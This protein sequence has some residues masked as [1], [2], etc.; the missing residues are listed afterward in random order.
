MRIKFRFT[1]PIN[2]GKGI[3][4]TAK[5]LLRVVIVLLAV[6]S[7]IWLT[8]QNSRIQTYLVDQVTASLK[9][10]LGIEVSVGRV[11]FRPFASLLLRDV[12]I[13]DLKGDT[14]LHSGRIAVT[15]LGLKL[16]PSNIELGRANFDQTTFNF[17]TDS[18]GVMNLS[19]LIRKIKETFPSK[20]DSS[21]FRLSANSISISNSR[22][23]LK[24]TAPKARNSDFGMNFQDMNFSNFNLKVDNLY[25]H[26]DTV[27]L[28]I[29]SLNFSDHSGFKLDNLR[30]NFS[31]CRSNMKF[32]KLRLQAHDSNI[33]LNR[34][35]FAFSSWKDFGNFVHSVELDAQFAGTYLKT[36][37]LSYFAP[38]FR[39]VDLAVSV[40]GH[41][42]GTISD[43][44][45]KGLELRYGSQ[46]L[47]RTNFNITGLPDIKQTLMVIDLYELSTNR[48]DLAA[49][50]NPSSGKPLVNLPQN[51]DML[52]TLTYKGNFTGYLNN[53]V[54]YGNLTSAIGSIAVDLSF[55]PDKSNNIDING[56]LRTTQLDVGK[57]SNSPI[58]GK[59]TL[60]ASLN[61]TID[62]QRKINFFTNATINSLQANSYTYN[63][64]VISGNLTNK[65]YSGSVRLNDPNCKLNF[66]GIIDFSDTIPV[67]DFSAFV[68]KLDLVKLNL[69]KKDSVSQ[70]SFLLTTKFRGSNLDNSSGEIKVVNSMYRNQHGEFKL[71]DVTINADNKEDSKVITLQ[72]DFAEGE[73][74]SKYNYSKFFTYLNNLVLK[75]IPAMK[76]ESETESSTVAFTGV[77][78]PE[79]NDYLVKFRLKKTEKITSVLMPQLSIAEN[80]SIFGILNPDLQTFSFKVRVP[81]MRFGNTGIKDL[82]AEGQ[83]KDSLFTASINTPLITIGSSKIENFKISSYLSHNLLNLAIGWQNTQ[84]PASRGLIEATADFTSYN[85]NGQL[86]SIAFNPSTFVINDS[87][88]NLSPST[89][90]IDTASVKFNSFSIRSRNQ[91]FNIDGKLSASNMDTLKVNLLNMDISYLNLYLQ[92]RG[93]NVSGTINGFAEIN[94][95]YQNPTLFSKLS[96][97]KLILN[98]NPIGNVTFSSTWINSEKR[99]AV[100]LTNNHEDTLTLKATGNLYTDDGSM[101]FLVDVNRVKLVHL[102]PLLKGSVSDLSGNVNGKIR[103]NGKTSKPMLNGNLSFSNATLTVDFLKSTFTIND[104]ISVDNSNLYFR[105]FKIT[106]RFNRVATINGDIKTNSFKDINFNIGMAAENFLCMNTTEHDNSQFYGTVFGTGPIFITGKPDNLNFNINLKTEGK[107]AIYL[108]IS[109]EKTVKQN[110]FISF[111]SSNPDQI[112][113]DEPVA[114]KKSK[115]NLNLNLDLLVTPDAEVQIIIDKKLGD[116]IKANGSGNLKMEISPEK[117]VFRMF[118]NFDIEKG[119]YLF[120]LQGVINKK[121][122]IMPGSSITWNGGPLDATMNIEAAYRVKTSLKQLLMDERYTTRVPVD[123]K[124]FLT[125]KLTSPVIKFGIEVP[126]ADAETKALVDGALN[127]EEKVNTQFLGLLVINSFI[128][129]PNQAGM[130]TQSS[131]SMGTM[132][133]YNTASE[134][135]SNQF[136][137]WISQWSN[138]VDIGVNYRP[139]MESELSSNQMEV[140]LSTQLLNDRVSIN[141]NVDVGRRSTS[142]P[143]AGDFNIDVKL[144]QSG[145]LRLKA[146]ARTNDDLLP[147]NQQNSYT[148]GV[149]VLYREDFNNMK[150]LRRR[151]RNT[152]NSEESFSPIIVPE[153]SS[154]P[155]STKDKTSSYPSP[156]VQFR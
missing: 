80:T 105:N 69:N 53:F 32:D 39:K 55:V 137:N 78:K 118:G 143:I 116:I 136:S 150:D 109:T 84:Q 148:T 135:L 26:R 75:Y 20:K 18:S 91:H 88:W 19:G 127:T 46:T 129:D 154:Q 70:A 141:G 50:T 51:F 131:S 123:C 58:L 71:D 128:A 132:G 76:P 134:L 107:T 11:D 8:L 153:N 1:I 133:L 48:E 119:D 115:V 62:N 126:N 151:I 117:D 40:D 74:R 82:A 99:M 65:T 38:V 85:K 110:N 130:M 37:T 63:D 111:V 21:D 35:N 36:S 41:V 93:Y 142:S 101:D 25:I 145:K 90:V 60:S 29:N 28:S 5:I 77:E 94:S 102:A 49:I 54:A 3:K 14:L 104:K 2:I 23:I 7:L 6:P 31:L 155:D 152:F 44:R 96:I 112:V 67:F 59:A 27:A 98:S 79:Y 4:K 114:T 83:T 34:L 89:V 64:I 66:M 156:F 73:L 144:N 15:L 56:N 81:Q 47:L 57:F 147:T 87:L 92:N 61:G 100:E 120:T 97:N 68:P 10:R 72:S 16:A 108:P 9:E 121:F 122:T 43:L 13:A 113:I 149:G 95:A 12:F 103:V 24:K 17:V 45:G 33:R 22:F 42:K 138:S 125:Q 106:D 124:I 140:A 52:S 146:F 139:G 86:T 30:A